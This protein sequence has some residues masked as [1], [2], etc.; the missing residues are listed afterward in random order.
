MSSGD[1]Y[2]GNAIS[3]S[4]NMLL[5]TLTQQQCDSSPSHLVSLNDQLSTWNSFRKTSLKISY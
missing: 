5:S 4:I 2:S 3:A 1:K